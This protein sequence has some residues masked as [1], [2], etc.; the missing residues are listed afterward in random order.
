MIALG[1]ISQNVNPELQVAVWAVAG[2]CC[3]GF[4]ALFRRFFSGPKSPDPWDETVAAEIEKD[5]AI[6][7]CHR[8]LTPHNSSAN[9]CPACGATVGTYTNWLP[10]PYVFSVGHTLRIGTSGDFKRSPLTVIGFFVFSLLEYTLFAPI[11]W[12]MFLLSLRKSRP[13]QAGHDTPAPVN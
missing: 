2:L 10:Y 9:F 11:Y 5:D 8:C 12:I 3:Y 6:P 13:S 4:W 1:Q 7:L